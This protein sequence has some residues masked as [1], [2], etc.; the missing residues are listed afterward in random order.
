MTKKKKGTITNPE[1]IKLMFKNTTED[2]HGTVILEIKLIR[3]ARGYKEK[4]L[5]MNSFPAGLYEA[6][7]DWG[8]DPL[9]KE[10]I[11]DNSHE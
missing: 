3:T 1:F 4:V 10:K 2:D 8:I 6:L 9:T 11:N 7:V 5:S